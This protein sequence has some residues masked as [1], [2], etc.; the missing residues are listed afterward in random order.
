MFLSSVLD[1]KTARKLL[2]EDAIIGVTVGSIE[3]AMIACEN[4]ADYLGIGTIFATPTYVC[5]N[6]PYSIFQSFYT[7]S[8]LSFLLILPSHAHSYCFV[9]ICPTPFFSRATIS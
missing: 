1:L 6:L 5:F 4:G 3:E 7:S 9:P 2:G 8:I